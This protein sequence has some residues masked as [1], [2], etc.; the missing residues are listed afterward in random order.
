MSQ[1]L[2]FLISTL[3][4]VAAAAFAL[5]PGSSIAGTAAEIDSD[6]DKALASL[7]RQMPEAKK[8]GETSKAVLVFPRII[9]GGLILVGGSGGEGALRVNGKTAGYYS[10]IAVSYGL[11][12]GA[13]WFGYAMFFRTDK[14]H[15]Y[16]D[17]SDGWEVGT[18]PSIVMVDK[19]A[20]TGFSSSS[21]KEDIYVFHFDQEGLMA[22][23]GLQGTKITKITP[24]K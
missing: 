9:K 1:P 14:A 12:L 8:L 22:G 7:Y 13:Q 2:R 15:A 5:M 17:S 11:Q 4:I 10:S 16:L 24:D 19:G 21:L 3:T 18:A 20:A 6:V 23:L